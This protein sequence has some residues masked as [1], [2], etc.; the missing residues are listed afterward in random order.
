MA[1]CNRMKTKPISEGNVAIPSSM[2][3]DAAIQVDE[4]NREET[5]KSIIKRYELNIIAFHDPLL[6]INA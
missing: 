6:P 4:D 2:E 1:G 5:H 3:Y